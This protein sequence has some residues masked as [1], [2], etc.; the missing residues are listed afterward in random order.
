MSWRNSEM[1]L[2]AT[3][4]NI[5]VDYYACDSISA[6]YGEIKVNCPINMNY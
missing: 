5:D 2:V 1:N 3:F 6:I 4:D